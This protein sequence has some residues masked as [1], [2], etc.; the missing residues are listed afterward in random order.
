[1]KGSD[2]GRAPL[3]EAVAAP[4]RGRVLLVV[5][6]PDDDV[7]GAGGTCCLHASAGDP[8]RVIVAYDGAL[9]NPHQ[10]YDANLLPAMREREAL[11]GG[12]ELGLHDYDFLGYP[13]GHRPKPP[14]FLEAVRRLA[15]RIHE[16]QPDIVYGPWIGEHH[17]DHHILAR[18]LR[19]ALVMADFRGTAWGFEVWS[20]LIATR[21][22]DI[23]EV[24]AR[25]RKALYRHTTQFGAS[26]QDWSH[27]EASLEASDPCLA[28]NRYRSIYLPEGAT[29]GEGFCPLGAPDAADLALLEAEPS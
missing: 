7:V 23:S 2:R 1:M 17:L 12:A 3:P 28:L 6:H 14:E 22:V 26:Q 19:A 18:V 27:A 9:G 8:V 21:V 4:E 16:W 25:K 10:R 11:A 5:P 29:Y 20:P 24:V 15:H 13:E